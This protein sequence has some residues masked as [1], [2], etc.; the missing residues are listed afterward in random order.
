MIWG[1]EGPDIRL[2]KWGGIELHAVL[3]RRNFVS[4]KAY[5]PWYSTRYQSL[6]TLESMNN[7]LQNVVEDDCWAAIFAYEHS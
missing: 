3:A 1:V 6:L 5:R 7:F 4:D 2:H